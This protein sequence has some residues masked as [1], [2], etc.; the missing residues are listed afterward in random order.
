MNNICYNDCPQGNFE[1]ASNL[2]S[3]CDA[4]CSACE[5]SAT[6]CTAC[7]TSGTDEAFLDGTSCVIETACPIGRYGETT[8]HVCEA[9]NTSCY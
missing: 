6:D 8:N 2:C 1:D 3:P 9:C 4:K 5:T 7:T